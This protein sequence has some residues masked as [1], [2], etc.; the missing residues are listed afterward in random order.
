MTYEEMDDMILD[1][2]SPKANRRLPLL[3]I[4]EEE[5]AVA[6]DCLLSR[7]GDTLRVRVE[8]ADDDM[9][10]LIA[11]APVPGQTDRFLYEEDCIQLAVAYPGSAAVADLLLANPLGKVTAAGKAA[12]WEVRASR[13]AEGWAIEVAIPADQ[14]VIG[15]SVHRYYRGVKNEVHGLL[16]ALP[17][18]LDPEEFVAI[19]LG[20]KGSGSSYYRSVWEAK[21]K[22]LQA[23]IDGAHA[24]LRKRK[25]LPSPWTDLASALADK[26][27]ALALKPGTGYLCWNEGHFQ[28][29]LLNLWEL[30]RDRAWLETAIG[31]MEGVW[32]FT[33]DR[34]DLPDN[35]WGIPQPTWYDH[36]DEAGAAITLTTGVILYPMA[37]LLCEVW[38]DESLADLRP[39]LEPWFDRCRRAIAVH[40]CEWVELPGGSGAYLEPYLKGPSRVYPR[41]G[42]R[43]APL[44]RM[45]FL[46]MPMLMLGRLLRDETYLDRVKRMARFF[47]ESMEEDENGAVV[48]EYET[49]YYPAT[50]EDISHAACQV[51]FAEL[52]LAEGIEFTEKDL[53]AIARTLEEN[54]F[55]HGDVPCGEVRGL[56]PD[57][58]MAVGAWS[59]LCRFVPDVL[60]RIAAVVETT[61]TERPDFFETQGWGIY[62]LTEVEKARQGIV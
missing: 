37:R 16:P 60:P 30:T 1:L 6:T 4:N 51:R 31:R 44:N 42:S 48:W 55:V 7:D 28:H 21:E 50:G 33:G 34:I 14:P 17:H 45:F 11:T 27:A 62:L 32:E 61:F 9:L 3:E 53:R 10:G 2:S 49:Q 38:Q 19:V 23:A 57:L 25:V 54:I 59:S 22:N 47:R 39:R 8:A 15:L 13:H 5:N 46:A 24:R 12:E 35:V 20:P 36:N 43:I 26:R 52:C 56:T 41:G 40:D 18:P 29:A 58:D